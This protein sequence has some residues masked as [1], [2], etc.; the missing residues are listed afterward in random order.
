MDK[1]EAPEMTLKV[2]GHQWY[3]SYQYPDNGN[4]SFDSYIIPDNQLKPGQLRLLSVDNNLVLPINTKIRILITSADVLHSWTVPAF[5]VKKD[6]VPGRINETWVKINK[7]GMY[8]G[9]CSELCGVNHG[10]MPIAVKAVT[11]EDFANWVEIAKKQFAYS[12]LKQLAMLNFKEEVI[13]DNT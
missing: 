11:P 12:S 6:A 10:F 9:Q 13:Y 2:L 5:G 3:W 4:F 8:Y 7:T 1:N